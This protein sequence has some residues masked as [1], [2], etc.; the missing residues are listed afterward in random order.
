VPADEAMMT[1]FSSRVIGRL[2]TEPS[3]GGDAIA[4]GSSPFRCA[5]RAPNFLLAIRPASYGRFL[6]KRGLR[7]CGIL[8]LIRMM[9]SS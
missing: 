9:M 2:R 8:L 3:T 6:P 7:R 4:M 5:V 1:R